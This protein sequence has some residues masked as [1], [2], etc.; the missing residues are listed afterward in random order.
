[1]TLRFNLTLNKLIVA[2]T[3]DYVN[4]TYSKFIYFTMTNTIKTALVSIDCL[5]GT[6]CHCFCVWNNKNLYGIRDCRY[7]WKLLIEKETRHDTIHNVPEN[8]VYS[9]STRSF[10]RRLMVLQFDLMQVVS[11]GRRFAHD[12]RNKN[13]TITLFEQVET[14]NLDGSTN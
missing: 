14:C 10:K 13:Q 1:M 3:V 9:L 12:F 7:C 5:I 2:Y 8:R 6:C 11:K 4:K